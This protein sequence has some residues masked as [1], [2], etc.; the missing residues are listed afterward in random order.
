MI[1]PI[2]MGE[3][4]SDCQNCAFRQRIRGAFFERRWFWFGRGGGQD[5]LAKNEH[6][7]SKPYK[8]VQASSIQVEATVLQGHHFGITMFLCFTGSSID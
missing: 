5:F 4:K 1:E 6:V 2:T 3:N 8:S 7:H